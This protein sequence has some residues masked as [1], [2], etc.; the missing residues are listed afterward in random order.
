MAVLVGPLALE[1]FRALAISFMCVASYSF[2]YVS[3]MAQKIVGMKTKLS[4]SSEELFSFMR[5][6]YN[7]F[8]PFS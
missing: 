2:V 3:L 7:T 4:F 8:E 5:L 1:V 6:Y